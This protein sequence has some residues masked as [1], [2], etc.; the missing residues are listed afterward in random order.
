LTLAA[1]AAAAHATAGTTAVVAVA[2]MAPAALVTSRATT[3]E[4]NG[5]LTI[6]GRSDGRHVEFGCSTCLPNIPSGKAVTP[7]CR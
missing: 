4:K 2:A 7:T 6:G 1:W 5:L 3:V